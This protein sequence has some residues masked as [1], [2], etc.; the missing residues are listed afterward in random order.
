MNLLIFLR[1]QNLW[2]Y[3]AFDSLHCFRE[4]WATLARLLMENINSGIELN[5]TDQCLRGERSVTHAAY[6]R[7]WKSEFSWVLHQSCLAAEFWIY[8]S[9]FLWRALGGGRADISRRTACLIISVIKISSQVPMAWHCLIWTKPSASNSASHCIWSGSHC[10][11]Y[12]EIKQVHFAP[13]GYFDLS[14]SGIVPFRIRAEQNPI[15]TK[16]Q[17]RRKSNVYK[18]YSS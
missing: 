7:S 11:S 14:P 16:C 15:C 5:K 12:P 9:M 10:P 4:Y 18:V 6:R 3:R 8:W 2:V 1:K 13:H 17:S